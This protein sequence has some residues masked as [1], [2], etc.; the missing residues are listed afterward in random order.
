MDPDLLQ[1]LRTQLVTDREAAIAQLRSDGADPGSVK[2][3]R[4]PGVSENFADSASATAER[5]ETLRRIE[6]V[7]DRLTGIDQALARMDQG[8]YGICERCKGPISEA[9]LEA[10]PASVLCVECA[11]NQP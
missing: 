6:Q 9:R 7:R 11:A 1:R 8:V 3:R 4:L 10:R 5:S 2:V